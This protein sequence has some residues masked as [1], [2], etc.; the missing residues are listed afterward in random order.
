MALRIAHISDTHL[1]YRALPKNDPETGRNQRALD[2]E[3][4]YRATIDDILKREVDLVIHSGDVFHQSRPS[5]AAMRWFVRQTRRLEE[6]G[7]P[8]VVI[9]GNH[10]TP[11]LRSAGTMFSVL[12]LALPRTKFAVGYETETFRFNELDLAVTAVPHGCL[13][14][15][16]PPFVYPDEN[17]KNILAI[18]GAIANADLVK[19][20]REAGEVFIPDTLLDKAFDY[21]ALGHIHLHARPLEN[22]WYAGSTE[23]FAWDDAAVSPGYA[24]ATIGGDQPLTVEHIDIPTRPFVVLEPIDG[25]ALSA[26]EIADRIAAKL[27]ENV[28]TE[29]MVRVQLLN[30]PRSVKRET[31]SILRRE[32]VGLVWWIELTS[33]RDLLAGFS[34]QNQ[35]G[36]STDLLSLF[37]A[38]V[39]EQAFDER[40]AA[41]FLS[42]GKTAI[43][44][45]VREAAQ[46]SGPEDAV[47]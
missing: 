35:E 40:F 36:P 7:L 17:R 19:E 13:T 8:V 31:E 27:R 46:S 5:W 18:H 4:A 16:L 29:A 43:E 30:T 21:I 44:D 34:R 11:R 38:F 37:D 1:G 25:D 42:R 2:V 20:Y 32:T 12:E 14:N 45:A 15:P 41:E 6:A 9:A 10:D 3:R 28:S 23:R 39:K 24:L 33:P 47:A 22:G 26:R